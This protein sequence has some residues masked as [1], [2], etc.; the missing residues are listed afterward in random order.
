[1]INGLYRVTKQGGG[2]YFILPSVKPV[3]TTEDPGNVPSGL[4]GINE[5]AFSGCGS[6][7][8]AIHF[9]GTVEEWNAI[10]KSESWNDGMQI[11]NINNNGGVICT[12]GSVLL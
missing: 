8:N 9:T 5:Y 11:G 3:E 7:N 1:M 2:E 12:D 6:I 10:S 4:V